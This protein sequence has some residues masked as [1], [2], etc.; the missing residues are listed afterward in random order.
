MLAPAGLL[1]AADGAALSAPE[2]MARVAANQDRA[3][4]LR[5]EYVYQQHVRVASIRTNGKLAREEITDYV[6]TPTPDGTKR[7]L[8]KIDG[9]YW[10]KGKYL[11]FHAEPVPESDSLDG[12]L[13]QDFRS[14]TIND[15]SKDSIARD[16]FPLTSEEQKQYAFELSGQETL[17]GRKVYRIR[18][19]PLDR[20]NYTWAGEA[21][22]DAEEFEPVSVFTHLSRR[23]PFWVR[24]LLGTNLPGF[25]YNVEYRRFDQGVWFPVSFG[26]EFRLHLVFFINREITISLENSAFERTKVETK[27]LD[28]KP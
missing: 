9:R 23:I 22:I 13:V 5:A 10:R 25:G 8:K 18:F 12:D 6:V 27:I 14:D 7:D 19:R 17:H 28:Y 24:T 16:L 4:K 11:E 2:I 21:L 20:N 1:L 15:K 26:T 3:E